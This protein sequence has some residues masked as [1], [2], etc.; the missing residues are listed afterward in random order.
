MASLAN[1]LTIGDLARR[2]GSATPA[3]RFYEQRGLIAAELTTGNQRRY[4]R[5]TL[6]TVAIIRAA[7]G[8]GLSLEEIQHALDT[9]PGGRTPTKRD[10]ERLSRSWRRGLDDRIEELEQL[11]DSLSSCIGCGCLSLRTCALFNAGDHAATRGVGP[12]YLLGDRYDDP[13]PLA[14]DA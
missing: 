1:H 3:I 7:Q 4:P 10:W 9:L 14:G 12:R 8:L 2:S 5:A 11:R 6:R 13:D